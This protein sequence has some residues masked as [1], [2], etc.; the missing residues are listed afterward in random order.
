M[1]GGFHHPVFRGQLGGGIGK[2]FPLFK[3]FLKTH[4]APEAKKFGISMLK[5]GAEEVGD[6][7]SGKR[8]WKSGLKRLGGHAKQ[9]A[10]GQVSAKMMKGGR[11][12]KVQPVGKKQIDVF[13]K[14]K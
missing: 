8:N 14:F 7:L 4:V 9:Q 10:L 2:L 13:S 12:T 5:K 3:S 11:R 1:G 6:V